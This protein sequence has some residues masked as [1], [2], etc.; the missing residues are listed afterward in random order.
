MAGRGPQARDGTQPVAQAGTLFLM[1]NVSLGRLDHWDTAI[2]GFGSVSPPSYASR[3]EWIDL[4]FSKEKL[5]ISL[6]VCYSALDTADPRVQMYSNA[7]GTELMVTYDLRT[8]SF[9]Y[10]SIVTQLCP[11]NSRSGIF[12]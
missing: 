2:G 7:I 1:I 6:S 9:D 5:Q 8:W 3:D 10:S 12:S 4:I 11:T